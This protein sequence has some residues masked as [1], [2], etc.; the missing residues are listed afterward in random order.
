MITKPKSNSIVTHAVEGTVI[1]F[2]VI[3]AGALK[4]DTAGISPQVRER[5]MIHGL[6]QRVCDA[7]A[8]SRDTTTGK[9]ASPLD[10]LEAMKG[11]VDHYASGA[12]EWS[13]KREGVQ[14]L[15]GEGAL[16][17]AV[18]LKVFPGKDEGKVREYVKA[19]SKEERIALLNSKDLKPAADALRSEAVKGID[20]DSLLADL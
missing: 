15:G 3:G 19:R 12:L 16:L 5:A 18:L 8:L 6:I 14:G 10:K 17:L 13:R 4:L 11:I 9:A 20:T 7:A 1:T 2:N